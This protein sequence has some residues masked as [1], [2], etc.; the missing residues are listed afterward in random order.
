M[1]VKDYISGIKEDVNKNTQN[2]NNVTSELL[3]F[4][5]KSNKNKPLSFKNNPIESDN[6]PELTEYVSENKQQ[7]TENISENKDPLNKFLIFLN[8]KIEDSLK[9][10][11][12]KNISDI[13][14]TPQEIF[15]EEIKND[16]IV[17]TSS[18]HNKKIDE[19]F[20]DEA[21]FLINALK[22]SDLSET[23]KNSNIS[24]NKNK[25]IPS[26]IYKILDDKS[27]L[28]QLESL[29]PTISSTDNIYLKELK[30]I[31]DSDKGT[32]EFINVSDDVKNYVLS[33]I[34]KF[35]LKDNEN[36]VKKHL[37]GA[38]GGGSDAR[39]YA[40]GGTMNGDL[41]V[42][43]KYLSGGKDLA[44][45]FSGTTNISG[46]TNKL[47]AG[48]NEMVLNT[49]GTIEFPSN[50]I[51]VPD[52]RLL[53][54]EA[55]DSSLE[56]YSKIVLSPYGFFAYDQN[57]NSISFDSSDNEII[58]TTLNTY[59][60]KFN[61][62][63]VL[64][65][66]KT[67]GVLD[68]A[69]LNSYGEILSGG[70]N[71]LEIIPKGQSAYDIWISQ[72]NIG[73]EQDFLNSLVG[74]IGL[75]GPDGIQGESG[76]N[77]SSAYDIWISNGN[78]GSLQEYLDSLIGPSG[79]QGIA[80]PKGD[81][82]Y[83]VWLSAGNI[84]TVSEYLSSLKGVQGEVG[85]TGQS[86]Y[87][88]WTSE[89]NIGSEQDF[90]NS[91]IGPKGDTGDTVVNTDYLNEGSVNLFYRSDRVVLD[92]PVKSVASKTGNVT[93]E[94]TDINNL[95]HELNTKQLTGNYVELVNNLIPTIYLPGTVDEIQEYT[96]FNTLTSTGTELQSV[97]Y[98]TLD[99]NKVYRWGGST[100][101]EI[102]G[103]PGTTDSLVEGSVNKYFT[104]ERASASAPVQSVANK[105]GNVLLEIQDIQNLQPSLTSTNTTTA[106]IT[107]KM[108]SN[109]G[110]YSNNTVIPANTPFEIIL[111]N[112]LTT[113]IPAVYTQ[114]TLTISVVPSTLSYEIGTNVS[115]TLT[116][117]FN[118][119]SAGEAS[120]FRIKT[121]TSILSST[122][123]STPFLTSFQLNTNTTFTTEVD[124]LS[125]L[126]LYDNIGNP[127]G[128]PILAGTKT[129]TTTFTTFRNNFYTSDTTSSS[130]SDS[131]QVR[132]FEN[133]TTSRSFNINIQ[134]GDKRV[135]FAFPSNLSNI[136]VQVVQVGFGNIT[137]AFTNAY[138]PATVS[139]AGANNSNST[140]YRVYTLLVS[141]GFP[142]A[143][144]YSISF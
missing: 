133:A 91:L 37:A 123:T 77:G 106:P 6:E 142:Q 114:P 30:S 139:V 97:L 26:K 119:G 93:L 68:V 31:F 94:I 52:K 22:N 44:E 23:L 109:L 33:Q 130:A 72:G 99:N 34:K 87:D 59:E 45:L 66:P 73:S 39:Q 76:L 14:E 47:V 96:N 64:I 105:Q 15:K 48:S 56:A 138:S 80:G 18:T 84:G 58:L 32:K 118:K 136:N 98:I 9:S 60:W 88:I 3:E 137:S 1:N 36:L 107:A 21:V 67:N 42:M 143:E 78:S 122:S 92:S 5:K 29:T 43:G 116:P 51:Q 69:G 62:E 83:Q 63:G 49:D 74:P 111:K 13:Q 104:I 101:V 85:E 126:Q 86:A 124:Y 25:K 57:S 120:Q 132:S 7:L 55:S 53:H 141:G 65:G 38:G 28:K 17:E 102:V 144:T 10:N 131:S 95:R 61:Q 115:P 82:S 75:V 12:Q 81:D 110:A 50:T 112:L 127:S 113:V 54:L 90:L 8:K 11:D 2:I 16:L 100:Y 19:K 134:T 40:N 128:N 24:E 41:N 4:Y 70:R 103:S 71:I 125:G 108:S 20:K 135:S 140:N 121:G 35:S 46:F 117:N 79:E 27:T 129:S 89:G